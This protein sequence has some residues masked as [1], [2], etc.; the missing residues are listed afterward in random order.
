EHG[1]QHNTQRDSWGGWRHGA[2]PNRRG[3]VSMES[4]APKMP[5]REQDL[6]HQG[7]SSTGSLTTADHPSLTRTV[8]NRLSQA[9]GL[10]MDPGPPPPP[11]PPP[12]VS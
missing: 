3:I 1:G 5:N 2:T 12:C 6:R 8:R 10:F 11:P 7:A 9:F 4:L